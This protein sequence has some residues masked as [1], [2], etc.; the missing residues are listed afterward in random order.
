M[1]AVRG[2]WGGYFRRESLGRAVNGIEWGIMFGMILWV[3]IA[4]CI[5]IYY[6]CFKKLD[7]WGIG[8]R[9]GGLFL[10][11]PYWDSSSEPSME[12]ESMPQKTFKKM[13]I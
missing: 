8:S 1:G 11:F 6:N 3:V 4:R 12:R 2:A 13:I 10:F 7:K 9:T 5:R